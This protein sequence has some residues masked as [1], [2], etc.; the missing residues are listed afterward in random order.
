M[1]DNPAMTV[2]WSC[3]CRLFLKRARWWI[4]SLGE[5]VAAIALHLCCCS[6][7]TAVDSMETR[8]HVCGCVLIKTYFI[9]TELNNFQLSHYFDF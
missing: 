8:E 2:V 9:D 6:A 1:F 4:L 5:L 3:S 7:E